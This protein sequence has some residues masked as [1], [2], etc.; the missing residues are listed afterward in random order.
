MLGILFAVCAA[1]SNAVGTV[2]Q[3]KAARVIPD[4]ESM[5]LALMLDLIRKPVWLAGIGGMIG[6]FG[7]Q[8]GALH[9]AELTLVQPIVVFELPL[10]LGMAALVFNRRI[11]KHAVW[12]TLA[13]SAGVSVALMAI[14]PQPGHPPSEDLWVPVVGVTLAAIAALVLAGAHTRDSRRAALF[15]VAA[16]IGFGFTA[17]LM[18]SALGELDH[19]LA[20]LFRSWQVYAMATA[21]IGSVFLTQNALQAGPIVA[22]QPAITSCDPLASIGYGV[23]VFGEHLRGG[24]WLIPT[25]LGAIV[26][27]GGTVLLAHSPL[28]EAGQSASSAATP[29][30]GARPDQSTTER[31][32][33]PRA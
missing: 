32:D 10:T 33:R 30:S 29:E 17:A 1:A 23:L 21:G 11:D 4:E 28:I 5:H 12:G 9:F 22:A 26:A 16:G 8:A 13:V 2:F 6:G 19:G 7:F 31:P 27:I 24:I 3:R 14:A 20:A 25:A 15:G 18:N